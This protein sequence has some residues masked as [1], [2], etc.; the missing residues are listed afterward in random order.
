MAATNHSN[1]QGV[2]SKCKDSGCLL[3]V[4]V[5]GKCLILEYVQLNTHTHTLITQYLHTT[6]DGSY[7]ELNTVW[8]SEEVTQCINVPTVIHQ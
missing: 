1:V 6:D 3:L 8:N 7:D 5:Y 4:F 2:I